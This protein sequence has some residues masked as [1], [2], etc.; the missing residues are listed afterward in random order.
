MGNLGKKIKSLREQKSMSVEDLATKIGKSRATVYRYENNDIENLPYTVL[1]PIADALGVKP[2]YLLGW[3]DEDE[4]R[5]GINKLNDMAKEGLELIE[6]DIT[7]NNRYTLLEIILKCT[8]LNDDDLG[9]ILKI[10]ETF[11]ENQ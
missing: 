5:E 7:Q 8:R 1:K 3:K 9:R 6:K 10:I 2:A 4:M 11:D